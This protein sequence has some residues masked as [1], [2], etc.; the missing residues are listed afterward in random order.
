M[1]KLSQVKVKVNND[2]ISNITKECAKILKVKEC[3]IQSIEILRRSID[4]R[5]KPD[6]YYVYT[7]LVCVNEEKKVLSRV[8]NNKNIE[9]YEKEF[10]SFFDPDYRD[11][12]K[13][14]LKHS[15]VIIGAG[16]AGLFAGYMLALH[17]YKPLII[18]RGKCVEERSIDVSNF[19]ETG[20]L[21]TKSNVQFGEGGA[22][23]F[24]D[25]KLNTAVKDYKSRNK[26]VL[27][28]FVSM[29]ANE[30]IRYDN[31]PH[32]G[33]DV[34]FN[35]LI[36]LRHEIENLGGSYLFETC[37]TNLILDEDGRVKGIETDKGQVIDTEVLI[38]APGHSAR[39]TFRYLNTTGL[40][41]EAKAF[42]VGFRVEHPQKMMNENQYGKDYP[43]H[44]PPTPYK[45]TGKG[46][47]GRGVY[48]FCMCPG[49][50]VVNASSE[51]GRTAVNG[52][53]YA[54]RDSQNA[55]SAIIVS[56]GPEDFEGKGPLAGV[57]YQEKLEERT[58]ALG[59]GKVPQQLYGDFIL[60][61]ASTS[62]GEFTSE[63]KGKSCFANLRGILSEDIN[64]AFME[65]MDQF[66]MKIKGFNREDAIMSGVESRTSS[67]LRI[68]RNENLE[69]NIPGLFPCGEGAGYAG[70]IMSAAMDGLKIAEE[71]G[72]RYLPVRKV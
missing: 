28:I 68:I 56:V 23:A 11:E 60:N 48:S 15:P 53:S 39:D 27:D 16:P 6:I 8:K 37:F 57:L 55:N 32:V 3:D 52:M 54:K 34:L 21:D 36:N 4:A 1:L 63:I 7:L 62:Y 45:V 44:L 61:R 14:L 17:G 71:I 5:K 26:Q 46:S 40:E 22:G 9:K 33:T 19:W 30:E 69:S 59:Q 72:R 50:F 51:E 24:S 49:G 10:Y 13:A 12:D 38:L 47:N 70:G 67:P 25:G 43:P 41:M 64:S 65:G 29:G 42:A 58:F 66:A 35:V 31:K 20:H 2:S 18:E